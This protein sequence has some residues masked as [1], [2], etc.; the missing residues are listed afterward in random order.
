MSAPAFA[1]K[2]YVAA[3]SFG[4]PCSTSPCG[5]G[6]FNEPVGV[7]ANDS[8]EPLTQP[9]AGD[10]YVVGRR[11]NRVERFSSTDTYIGQFDGSG[12]LS[13]EAKR[14][15]VVGWQVEVPTGQFVS[16]DEIAVDNSTS[17]ADPSAGDVYV[18]DVGNDV[19]DKFSSTG[20]YKGQLTETT[21]G[22]RLGAP[23]GVA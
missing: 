1:A 18:E 21:G 3:G 8:K 14:R 6:Q 23:T 22:A 11:D 12:L 20:E 7:A 10:V 9:A 5:E 4:E 15:A 13:G 17:L 16:P 19:I 2:E